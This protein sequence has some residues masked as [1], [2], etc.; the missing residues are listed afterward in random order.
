M[1][2]PARPP[3]VVPMVWPVSWRQ[4]SWPARPNRYAERLWPVNA[5]SQNSYA[6][7]PRLT[8]CTLFGS[9]PEPDRHTA[10]SAKPVRVPSAQGF[11][12]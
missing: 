7:G 4:N 11:P 3:L 1:S 5:K 12:I 6:S 2:G 8:D 10:A 9:F